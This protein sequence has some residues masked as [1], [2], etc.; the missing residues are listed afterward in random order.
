MEI[1]NEEEIRDINTSLLKGNIMIQRNNGDKFF[2]KN[3][4]L[5][6]G[7]LEIVEKFIKLMKQKN[8]QY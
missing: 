5:K 2:I 4:D 3:T 8:V 7:E 6:D 1:N